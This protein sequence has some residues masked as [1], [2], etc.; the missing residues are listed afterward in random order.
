[1]AA[2]HIRIGLHPETC[3]VH[4]TGPG[5]IKKL[6]TAMRHLICKRYGLDHVPLDTHPRPDPDTSMMPFFW[7]AF[8]MW[9]LVRL[10]PGFAAC[11]G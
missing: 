1:M 4:R 7:A 6:L 5:K 10:S 11:A 3:I 2:L 8:H 9:R